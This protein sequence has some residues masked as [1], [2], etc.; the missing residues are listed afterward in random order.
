MRPKTTRWP[1]LATFPHMNCPEVVYP[2]R[3][4]HQ[5]EKS[6]ILWGELLNYLLRRDKITVQQYV[7]HDNLLWNL[8]LQE[9]KNVN[10]FYRCDNCHFRNIKTIVSFSKAV[11][12]IA[13]EWGV[14]YSKYSKVFE[15]MS[16]GILSQFL[17]WQAVL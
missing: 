2:W 8:G 3:P 10:V 17:N 13:A 5:Q 7:D 14:P 9:L 12:E 16:N 15:Q 4:P 11:Q 1:H 6:H